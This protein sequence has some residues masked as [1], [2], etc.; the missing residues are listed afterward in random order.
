MCV[1][2]C[3][4]CVCDKWYVIHPSQSSAKCQRASRE[5]EGNCSQDL[6]LLNFPTAFLNCVVEFCSSEEKDSSAQ[7]CWRQ[8]E[9]PAV[10]A[11]AA[12]VSIAITQLVGDMS[13]DRDRSN[14]IHQLVR[15]KGKERE[16]KGTRCD[17]V[18][19]RE[20]KRDRRFS[21]RL[22]THCSQVTENSI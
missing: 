4:V 10:R 7:F 19:E 16:G 13:A 2:V 18:S 9:V 8:L 6:L 14:A 21:L 3:T 5:K 22:L 15:R 17:S 11:A 12:A 1:C 20:R